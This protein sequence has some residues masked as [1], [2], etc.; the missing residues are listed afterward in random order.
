MGPSYSGLYPLSNW[1]LNIIANWR[2]GEWITQNPNN[3]FGINNNLQV[4]DFYNIDLRLSK[5]FSVKT[6][7]L[8]FS[9]EVENLLNS[10]FLSGASFWDI[11]DQLYYFRSLHLPSSRGYNNIVGDDR[12]GEYRK[13]GVDYQP[14]EQVGNVED[15]LNP[16]NDV[17]YYEN[18]TKRYMQYSALS[19]GDNG[20]VPV[21]KS[22]LDKVLKDKAYID[23]PNET[24]FNFLNPRRI[25]FGVNVSF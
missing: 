3:I 18:P 19:N 10:K 9:V 13:D 4:K 16:V 20:W 6:L 17:I 15:V 5:R 7:N 23:M 22:R 14:I 8:T 24:S 21:E 2:A 12:A 11:N 25:S 1:S